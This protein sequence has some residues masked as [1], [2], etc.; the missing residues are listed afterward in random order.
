MFEQQFVY[1]IIKKDGNSLAIPNS[2]NGYDS[3]EINALYKQGF[4]FCCEIT[5]PDPIRAVEIYN[6]MI[7]SDVIRLEMEL[8][9]LQAAYYE[10]QRQNENLKRNSSSW[11]HESSGSFKN[12]ELFGFSEYPN[13]NELKKRYKSLCMRLHPD[14]NG[15]K[16]LFQLVHNAYQALTKI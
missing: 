4:V 12:F 6:E 2:F 10:L 16:Q 7:K 5:A 13:Q 11:S 3:M 14:R 9:R 1:K 15:D 8:S